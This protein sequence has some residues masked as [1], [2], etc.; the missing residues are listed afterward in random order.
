MAS[1]KVKA[2]VEKVTV[3]DVETALCDPGRSSGRIAPRPVRSAGC[4]SL[5]PYRSGYILDN[6]T[7]ELKGVIN[8][9]PPK[10]TYKTTEKSCEGTYGSSAKTYDPL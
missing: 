1:L 7:E 4:C 10:G 9:T 8:I 3:E 5:Y 6:P 2:P